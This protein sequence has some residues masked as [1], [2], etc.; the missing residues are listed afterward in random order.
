MKSTQHF[1]SPNGL[2]LARERKSDPNVYDIYDSNTNLRVCEVDGYCEECRFV[3]SNT[4]FS[5]R[6]LYDVLELFNRIV[7]E[8][9]EA[10]A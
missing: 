6:K 5:S 9:Q 8:T 3:D 4:S 2:M 7:K 10:S 1:K